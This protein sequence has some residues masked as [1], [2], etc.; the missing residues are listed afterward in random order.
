MKK[1]KTLVLIMVLLISTGA[2]EIAPTALVQEGD[3]RTFYATYN[4]TAYK[5]TGSACADGVYP[6]EGVTVACN[7]PN[8][9]H[10]VTT[11]APCDT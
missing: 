2:P 9:W 11:C 5:S 6:C 3:E 1:I 10:K 8:L 4:C 7:D